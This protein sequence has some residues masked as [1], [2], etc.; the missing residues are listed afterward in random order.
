MTTMIAKSIKLGSTFALLTC[1][2]V[3]S[4]A[5]EGPETALGRE[6][7]R[8]PSRARNE[9]A[10]PAQIDPRLVARLEQLETA[11]RKNRDQSL[12]DPKAWAAG[13]DQRALQHRREIAELWG[14][15]VNGIDGQAK[16][17]MHAE[18][19][20]RF[21]RML[22]LAEYSADQALVARLHK[23]ITREL[24]RHA[25]SMQVTVAAWGA[26]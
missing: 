4:G 24:V 19:M 2:A 14:N 21:N 8:T 23:D 15:V 11:R 1:L 18:R 26:Q 10:A 3:R 16:L 17:R 7:E 20:S 5:Q 22:D 9:D 13:R 12:Q 6:S 25:K